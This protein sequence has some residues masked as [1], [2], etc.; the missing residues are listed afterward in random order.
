MCTSLSENHSLE[1]NGLRKTGPVC[2]GV[3]V[4]EQTGKFSC[5]LWHL[6]IAVM[7]CFARWFSV[8]K[9]VELNLVLDYE[10]VNDFLW[11]I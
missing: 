2:R 3:G 10:Q 4:G 6:I 5:V 7:T 11:K 1:H 9:Y 8:G